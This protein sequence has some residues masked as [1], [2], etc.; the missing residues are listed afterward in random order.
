MDPHTQGTALVLEGGGMRGAYTAGVL[1]AFLDEHIHFP[2][3]IGV[4]AGANAG[5]DYVAGQRE[6]NYRVF[7][8]FAG[9]RRYAGF[10]NLLRECSWFGMDFLFRTLPDELAPFDYEMF[11]RT[12]Q[13]FVVGATDCATG[14]AIYFRHHDYDPR[15]FVQ[16]VQRASSSLPVLSPPVEVEGRRYLDGGLSDPIPV[17]RAISDGNRRCV[18][19]LTRNAGYRK[20]PEGPGLAMRLALSRYP[21]LRQTLAKR[22]LVYNAILERLAFLEKTGGAF[23]L[24]PVR[25]LAVGRLERRVARLEE[26]Y[27]QGYR[28]TVERLPEL[29]AWLSRPVGC[30]TPDHPAAASESAPTCEGE[31]SG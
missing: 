21:A 22:H 16:T 1:D 7:V 25:A 28:E 13:T 2:Y 29:Q 26:L 23:V 17:E 9:D 11:A 8:E 20:K 15:W 14:Q 12:P 3:V 19:I 27:H 31:A 4:S 24:R 10:A 30:S 5:S 18:V 6:R